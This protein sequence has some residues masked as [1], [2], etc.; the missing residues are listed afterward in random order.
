MYSNKYLTFDKKNFVW[1]LKFYLFLF[2]YLSLLQ[3]TY[4]TIYNT[5]RNPYYFSYP[6]ERYKLSRLRH[7][8]RVNFEVIQHIK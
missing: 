3:H 5:V 1:I 6:N 4:I 7:Q 2:K 8:C